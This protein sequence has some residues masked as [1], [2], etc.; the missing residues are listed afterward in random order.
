MNCA[1]RQSR[2]TSK[3]CICL[4]AI[5]RL[6]EK[7]HWMCCTGIC[8]GGNNDTLLEVALFKLF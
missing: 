8:D 5:I 7:N 2:S 3:H 1:V 6:G 4:L